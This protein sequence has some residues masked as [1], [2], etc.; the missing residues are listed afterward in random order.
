MRGWRV[1]LSR[2]AA[3]G[4]RRWLTRP[5]AVGMGGRSKTSRIS[6]TIN[7]TAFFSCPY[8]MTFCTFGPSIASFIATYPRHV[9]SCSGPTRPLSSRWRYWLAWKAIERTPVS[10]SFATAA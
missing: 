10:S 2:S 4:V 5:N 3:G 6:G 7:P 9:S 8:A 1:V